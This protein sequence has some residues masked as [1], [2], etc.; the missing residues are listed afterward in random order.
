[1]AERR[2][3]TPAMTRG[4]VR[5]S[6]AERIAGALAGQAAG[7]CPFSFWTHVPDV[8]LDA[9]KLA[10]VT[11]SFAREYDVDFVKTMPN[12]MYMI[13]DFG[14]TIDFSQVA[15]GGVAKVVSTPVT[16]PED[17]DRIEVRPTD[18]G[19][20]GR[21]L[22]SLRRLVSLV[23]DEFPI[24]F[25]VFSPLTVAQKVSGGRA[26]GWIRDGEGTAGL[27]RALDAIGRSVA[28]VCERAV[29]MGAAG[30]F[31]ATQVT[32]ADQL[33][34]EQYAEFARDY[35]VKALAGAGQGWFNVLHLHGANVRFEETR[36]YPVQALNWHVWETPPS[37][38]EA[39]RQTPKCLVGG[40]DR[41]C[42][43]GGDRQA[44]ARQIAASWEQAG[45]GGLIITPGCV[46][47]PPLDLPFLSFIRETI[48]AL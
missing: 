26:L 15:S 45:G 40:I 24:V 37:V 27:H 2:G 23:G 46:I 8:D 7:Q 12:G 31:F 11:A 34:R 35:D 22:S 16:A 13:E 28:A 9:E 10:E 38:S 1:M 44:V 18:R 30:V 43:S 25:T 29:D 17:W 36:D 21:E 4:P 48:R 41:R 3:E 14:C 33:S 32:D 39:R 20:I 47:R 6:K 19:A 42:I 5:S